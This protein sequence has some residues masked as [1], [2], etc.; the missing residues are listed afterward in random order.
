MDAPSQPTTLNPHFVSSLLESESYNQNTSTSQVP[1]LE[2]DI[3]GV[4]GILYPHENGTADSFH[5][6]DQ[7]I[8]STVLKFFYNQSDKTTLNNDLDNFAFAFSATVSSRNIV[9]TVFADQDISDIADHARTGNSTNETSSITFTLHLYIF[10]T[11]YICLDLFIIFVCLA[12]KR[13]IISRPSSMGVLLLNGIFNTNFAILLLGDPYGYKNLFPA[14]VVTF[15]VYF[16]YLCFVVSF[17]LIQVILKRLSCLK[18]VDLRARLQRYRAFALL[19]L[20][21][22]C[23]M[24]IIGVI[25]SL[26]P[27]LHSLHLI[28]QAI[29]VTAIIV[30][31]FTF[32]YSALN[33]SQYTKQTCRVLDESITYSKMQSHLKQNGRHA[34]MCLDL[35]RIK[36]GKFGYEGDMSP[37]GMQNYYSNGSLYNGSESSSNDSLTFCNKVALTETGKIEEIFEKRK[38]GFRG[39]QTLP[40]SN[41]HLGNCSVTLHHPSQHYA[42]LESTSDCGFSTEDSDIVNHCDRTEKANPLYVSAKNTFPA[43][44]HM[45]Q[46]PN[47]CVTTVFC[48]NAFNMDHVGNSNSTEAKDGYTDEVCRDQELLVNRSCTDEI[49]CFRNSHMVSDCEGKAIVSDRRVCTIDRSEEVKLGSEK[50]EDNGYLADSENTVFDDGIEPDEMQEYM[51]ISEPSK[52]NERGSRRTLSPNHQQSLS[53]PQRYGTYLGLQRVRRGRC[54]RKV[55]QITYCTAIFAF[56]LCVLELYEMFS[57]RGVLTGLDSSTEFT[58]LLFQSFM[59]YPIHIYFKS[60][61]HFRLLM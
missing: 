44:H 12:S 24:V 34:D 29:Y 7:V 35:Y 50:Q 19:C 41:G 47:R 30:L 6:I 20:G 36:R 25:T 49:I 61:V 18:Q 38:N 22:T 31:C 4:T 54:V 55:M 13:K 42:I 40:S 3:N 11:L 52:D 58:W 14:L 51:E 32:L 28:P 48:N 53:L 46:D 37:D 39:T 56:L 2:P 23:V 9:T 8:N 27:S 1:T 43:K 15:I 10:T 45:H 21:Y 16:K 26:K 33:I 17:W 5:V 59:R 57:V 60:F